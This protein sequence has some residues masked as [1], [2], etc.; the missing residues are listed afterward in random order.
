MEHPD[1]AQSLAERRH[2]AA[3]AKLRALKRAKV[4]YSNPNPAQRNVG[5]LAATPTPCSCWM[6]RNPRHAMKG[7]AKL[8][9]QERRHGSPG[10]NSF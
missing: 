5:R 9:I 8:T 6:C 2:F 4:M 1:G 7:A 3:R 10:D